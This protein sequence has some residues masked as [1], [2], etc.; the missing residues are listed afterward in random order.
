MAKY[1]IEYSK[2]VKKDLKKIDKS[3]LKAIVQK[4]YSLVEEPRLSGSIKLSGTRN[5]YRVRSG[6]Y[7]IIYEIKDDVLVVLVVKVGHRKDVYK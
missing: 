1:T 7:R 2:S 3:S 4:I 5:L 6:D